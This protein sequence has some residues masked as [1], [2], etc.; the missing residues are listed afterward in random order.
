[1]LK[2]LSKRFWKW[3]LGFTTVDEVIPKKV[4]GKTKKR[5]PAKPAK[6]D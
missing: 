4:K 6:P 3:V 2:A 1:M 5:Q